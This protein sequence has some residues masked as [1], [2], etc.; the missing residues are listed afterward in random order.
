MKSI[1]Q[2]EKQCIV[3]GSWNVEEHHLYK[4]VAKRKLSEQYGLK[5]FLCPTHHRGTNGVHGKNGHK[6]DLELKILGQK[7]FEYHYGSREDFIKIFGK[8]YILEGSND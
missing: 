4:G 8:S 2:H 5:I 6:L 3:C 7:S 1:I